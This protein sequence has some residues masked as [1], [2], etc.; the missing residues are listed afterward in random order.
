[1]QVSVTM[2]MALYKLVNLMSMT[3]S[4]VREQETKE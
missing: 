4:H 2:K 3:I 1:M